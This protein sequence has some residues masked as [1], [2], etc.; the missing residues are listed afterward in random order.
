[1]LEDYFDWTGSSEYVHS[2]KNNDIDMRL[3][4]W[5]T[6][7]LFDKEGGNVYVVKFEVALLLLILLIL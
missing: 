3:W 5:G 2:H 4:L 7:I 6:P 1:M